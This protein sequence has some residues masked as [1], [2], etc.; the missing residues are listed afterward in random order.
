M[1]KKTIDHEERLKLCEKLDKDLDEFIQTREKAPY[2]EGWDESNWENV[3][4][5]IVRRYV[6]LPVNC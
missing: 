4:Y 3:I 2:T 5:L 6:G 1:A